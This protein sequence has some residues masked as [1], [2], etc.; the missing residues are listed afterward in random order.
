MQESNSNALER[1]FEKLFFTVISVKVWGLIAGTTISTI[2]LFRGY[3]TGGQWATFNTTVWG[4]IFGM[5]EIFKISNNREQSQQ[6]IIE[7]QFQ[8]KRTIEE[9]ARLKKEI[10]DQSPDNS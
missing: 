9:N 4:L 1:W 6:R 2:L 5:K 10:A 7:E 3:L 8:M